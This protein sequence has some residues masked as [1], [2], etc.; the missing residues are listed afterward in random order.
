MHFFVFYFLFCVHTYA[1]VSAL[2]F[3]FSIVVSIAPAFAEEAE[4]HPVTAYIL[5]ILFFPVNALD[6]LNASL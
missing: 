6:I 4:L 5:Y 1:F 3:N 2:A